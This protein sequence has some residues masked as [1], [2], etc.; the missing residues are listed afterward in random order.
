MSLFKKYSQLVT[1]S[2]EP[3]YTERCQMDLCKI[4]SSCSMHITF[5][6]Q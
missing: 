5:D 4:G 6:Y 1:V 3:S 2:P